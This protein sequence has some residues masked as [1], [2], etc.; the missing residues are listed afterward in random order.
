MTDLWDPII[1]KVREYSKN[2]KNHSVEKI[3]ALQQNLQPYLNKYDFIK[4]EKL[5]YGR[6]LVHQDIDNDFNIQIDVFSENYTGQIHCHE[7]WGILHVFRGFLFVEDW[8]ELSNNKFRMRSCSILN[9]GSSQTFCPPVS[10]WHKVSSSNSKYQ[11]ISMHIYGNGFN[12]D[13]G[14]YLDSEY[15]PKEGKR[16]NFKELDSINRILKNKIF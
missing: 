2:N 5:P 10:D 3:F 4:T 16:S 9:P 6:Y 13:K 14:I 15:N 12:I 8:E 11:V 7:T 1:N